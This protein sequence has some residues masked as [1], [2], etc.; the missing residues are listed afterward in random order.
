MLAKTAHVDGDQ[1]QPLRSQR[2]EQ[3]NHAQVPDSCWIQAGTLCGALRDNQPRQNAKRGNR[4][5]RRNDECANVYEY[6]MHLSQHTALRPT[7]AAFALSL[8]KVEP[9]PLGRE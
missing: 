8:E 3:R 4:A 7:A 9:D 6:R 5:V 1:Q 2:G